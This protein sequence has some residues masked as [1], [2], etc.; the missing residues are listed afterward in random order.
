MTIHIECLLVVA[1]NNGSVEQ[2]TFNN[3]IEGY[4]EYR[5]KRK[6]KTN[7]VATSSFLIKCRDGSFRKA[8]RDKLNLLSAW[9][10]S[11]RERNAA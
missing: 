11:V 9:R 3:V 4:S 7:G 6:N 8:T 5:N 1:Y 10:N 2:K